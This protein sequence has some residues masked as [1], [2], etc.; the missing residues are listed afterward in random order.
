MSEQKKDSLAQHELGESNVTKRNGFWS[1]RWRWVATIVVLVG[2]SGGL[3]AFNDD[4]RNFAIVKN[5]DI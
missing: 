1:R 4:D 5:L 3:V 2:I